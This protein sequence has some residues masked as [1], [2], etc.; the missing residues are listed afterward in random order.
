MSTTGTPAATQ[1]QRTA[2]YTSISDG[3][4]H[5]VTDTAFSDSARRQQGQTYTVCG[6]TIYLA[7]AA[8]PCGPPCPDCTTLLPPLTPQTNTRQ[9]HPLLD[10][11][12]HLLRCPARQVRP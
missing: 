11:A 7:A 6:L 9:R 3:Y 2:W 4:D 8:T 1:R 10:W 5:A 12:R